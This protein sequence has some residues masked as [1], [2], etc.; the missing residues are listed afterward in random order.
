M[1]NAEA[2]R[3]LQLD[4][5]MM[6]F[7]PS[8]GEEAYLNDDAK[9]TIE[10]LEMA[11]A[12]LTC[13]NDGKV[14]DSD[15]VGRQAAIDAPFKKWDVKAGVTW[16]PLEHIEQLP[17]AQ[18]EYTEQDVKDAYHTG[19]SVG[20]EAAQPERKTGRWIDGKLDWRGIAMERYCS[21]CG[22]LLTSAKTVRM[23]FCPNCGADMKGEKYETD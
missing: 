17:P 8:T 13:M 18:P 12:A 20:M 9:K 19:F 6:K 10:A 14:H 11:I 15:L 5:D 2:I 21:E 22:Q 16:I 1:T 3:W 23:N 7:D 4:I